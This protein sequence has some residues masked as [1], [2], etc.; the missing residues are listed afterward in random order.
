MRFVPLD[1]ALVSAARQGAPD[2]NG[3]LPERAISDGDG[4]PCRCCLR[5]IETGAPM[6]I[7][8][9]RPF[10][11]ITPYAELGPVFLHAESCAPHAD[12]ATPEVLTRS[13]RYLMKGYDAGQRIVGGTGGVVSAGDVAARAR[14][15]LEDGRVAFVDVRSASNNCWLARAVR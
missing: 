5:N 4:N 8:A 10:T 11:T 2:A 1:P 13:V 6:L 14:E 9:V 3:Q 12:A 15:L 7:L